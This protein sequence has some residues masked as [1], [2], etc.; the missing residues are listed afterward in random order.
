M[1]TGAG[2]ITLGG[3]IGTLALP[4]GDLSFTTTSGVTI[5]GLTIYGKSIP[6]GTA[7]PVTLSTGAVAMTASAAGNIVFNSTINGAQALTLTTSGTGYTNFGGNVG[8]TTP[9]TSLTVNGATQLIANTTFTT[10]GAV[11]FEGTVDGDFSFTVNA[12]TTVTLASNAGGTTPLGAVTLTGTGTTISNGIYTNSA[13]IDLSGIPVTLGG[14]VTLGS[15][16]GGTGT[17]AN[18][19]LGVVNGT[20]ALSIYGGTGTINLSDVVGTTTTLG[21]ITLDAAT[22]TVAKGFTTQGTVSITSSTATN[23]NSGG[24]ISISAGSGLTVSGRGTATISTNITSSGQPMTFNSPVSLGANV[25]LSAGAGSITFNNT[26]NGA[27][28]L[29]ITN[30]G[31]GATTTFNGTLGATT[32]ITT[33]SVSSTAISI[34]ADQTAA[35]MTYTGPLTMLGGLVFTQSGSGTLTFSSTITG[36]YPLVV[37]A[38]TGAISIGGNINTSGGGAS[39]NGGDV[40]LISTGGNVTIQNITATGNGGYGGAILLQ[41]AT[42]STATVINAVA[43]Q[44][45]N[46]QLIINGTSISASGVGG[47]DGEVSLSPFGRSSA[48]G[49]ATITAP[50]GIT[51]TCGNFIKGQYECLTAFGNVT[52]TASGYTTFADIVGTGNLTMGGAA[53]FD[54]ANYSISRGAITILNSSGT[55]TNSATSHVLI[56]TGK[57]LTIN[58]NYTPSTGPHVDTVAG[59]TQ[60]TLQYTDGATTYTL[61]FD[62]AS[63]PPPPP[64]SPPSPPSPTPGP[65]APLTAGESLETLVIANTEFEMRLPQIEPI[66]FGHICPCVYRTPAS[67]LPCYHCYHIRICSPDPDAPQEPCCHLDLCADP[68]I[69]FNSFIFENTVR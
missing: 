53:A 30:T 55:S 10:T 63:S 50:N 57:T 47:T 9:L 44:I 5:Q 16:N 26:V 28:T 37:K 22:V 69:Q 8:G 45:P 61:N 14:T 1:T 23:L 49:I 39:G 12:G 64:P 54:P 59:L 18:I 38:I 41:P 51:I 43:Y 19:T 25:A 27:K 56:P 17:G 67:S 58:N 40:S 4:M 32:P 2:A 3:N 7:T 68:V 48:Q 21:N 62:T 52:I 36:N 65:S 15:F 11:D 34:G 42:G 60:A 29:T 66:F 13:A 35:A 31:V 20:Q 6:F 33:L 24:S 46:G